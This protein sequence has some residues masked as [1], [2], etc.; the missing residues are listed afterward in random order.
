MSLFQ[1]GQILARELPDL[2]SKVPKFE[3]PD[4]AARALSVF[5]RR[6]RTILPELGEQ[7]AYSNAKVKADLG[8]TLHSADDAASAAVRS[9]RD[10]RLI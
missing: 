2:A 4:F 9:L 10:L 1:L 8:L 6:L 7:K 3:L 5:D